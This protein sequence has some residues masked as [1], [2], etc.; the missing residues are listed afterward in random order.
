MRAANFAR[1]LEETSRRAKLVSIPSVGAK[2]RERGELP[3]LKW[4]VKRTVTLQSESHPPLFTL[5]SL[6]LHLHNFRLHDQ[7]DV[8]DTVDA[9]VNLRGG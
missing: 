2:E 7:P 9:K 4:E 5:P 1:E 8:G 3:I 6:P